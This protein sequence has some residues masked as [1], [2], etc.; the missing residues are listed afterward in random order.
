MLRGSFC[1]PVTNR[2]LPFV[3]VSEFSP[4][5]RTF[6]PSLVSRTTMPH[7]N[8][9][10]NPRIRPRADRG[11]R[12]YKAQKSDGGIYFH[13]H[14]SCV[15]VSGV[16]FSRREVVANPKPRGKEVTNDLTFSWTAPRRNSRDCSRIWA[17]DR[18]HSKE[19]RSDS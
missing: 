16:A 15:P 10:C 9:K 11:S 13:T 18:R 3:R 14:A 6:L 17:R 8:E 7:H 19:C 5:P 1:A 2:I 4:L 12:R